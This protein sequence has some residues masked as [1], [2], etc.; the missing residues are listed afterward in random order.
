MNNS[1]LY[2][3]DKT[4]VNKANLKKIQETIKFKKLYPETKGKKIDLTENIFAKEGYFFIMDNKKYVF[5]NFP[6]YFI[7]DFFNK[8]E[9][10][11]TESDYKILERLS[12]G[13]IKEFG[14]TSFENYRRFINLTFENVISF[15]ES[16]EINDYEYFPKLLEITDTFYIFEYFPDEKFIEV[17]P[18]IIINN[19]EL[20]IKT[21]N[22]N[23]GTIFASNNMFDWLFNPTTKEFKY[24]DINSI[25]YKYPTIGNLL[26][27]YNSQMACFLKYASTNNQ[28]YKVLDNDKLIDITG[29]KKSS[30]IIN[31]IIKDIRK[32]DDF[33]I[34]PKQLIKRFNLEIKN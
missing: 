5:K 20:F 12:P 10:D 17:T 25:V 2:K 27:F 7:K 6:E 32:L 31:K 21:I 26:V 23:N 22:N 16:G 13:V 34:T 11:L 3:L 33:G 14:D 29:K 28:N 18:E 19:R 9:K 1:V 15:L 8:D 30:F 24:I 4:L